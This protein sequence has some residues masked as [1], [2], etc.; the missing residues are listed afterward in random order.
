MARRESGRVELGLTP[1][2]V[3]R[4]GRPP[5]ACPRASCRLVHAVLC[6]TVTSPQTGG[7][8]SGRVECYHSRVLSKRR[9]ESRESAAKELGASHTALG[10]EIM[11]GV[12]CRRERCTA[13]RPPRHDPPGPYSLAFSLSLSL[14]QLRDRHGMRMQV[15]TC[16]VIETWRDRRKG[17]VVSCGDE[18]AHAS[19]S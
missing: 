11:R 10:H 15:T 9:I 13:P 2:I 3:G 19:L 6:H 12:M 16:S 14:V 8:E 7:K 4:V 17:R 18:A 1:D 5:V